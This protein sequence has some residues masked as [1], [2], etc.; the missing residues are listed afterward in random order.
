MG[1]NHVF[2]FVRL[3]EKAEDFPVKRVSAN[4]LSV[5]VRPH[6]QSPH[7]PEQFCRPPE[8]FRDP[9]AAS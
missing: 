6:P 2:R 8:P 4:M 3:L 5:A 9:R 7:R 1:L